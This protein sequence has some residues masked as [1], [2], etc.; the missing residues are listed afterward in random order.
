M[1]R[2]NRHNLKHSLDCLCKCLDDIYDINSGGCCYIA[3]LIALHLDKLRIKYKLIIYD[4]KR[5][6][7][8]YVNEEILNRSLP[9][10]VTGKQTCLH[11]CIFIPGGGIIN[12]GDSSGLRKYTVKDITNKNIKWLYKNGHWN[13]TYNC[14]NNKRIK[15]IINLFFS[16]YE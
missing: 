11:Y 15:G 14:S 13:P 9:N 10:S 12:K 6:D 4:D 2:I 3:Y 5:L 8:H 1:R 7:E 16:K